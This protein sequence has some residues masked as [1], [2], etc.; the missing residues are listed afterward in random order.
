M[1]ERYISPGDGKRRGGVL[2]PLQALSGPDFTGTMGHPAHE[3]VD[4]LSE[5]G[6]LVWHDLP[7]APT[8]E[9]GCPYNSPSALAGDPRRIDIELVARSGALT[10]AQ[11]ARYFTK[12]ERGITNEEGTLQKLALLSTAFVQ[13][14][15][16]PSSLPKARFDRWK[17]QQGSWL[18]SFAAYTALSAGHGTGIWQQW[19][20][21]ARDHTPEA[22]AHVRAGLE[23]KVAQYVQWLFHEQAG[24][25]KTEANAKDVGIIGDVPFYVSGFSADVWANRSLFSVDDQGYPLRRSGV[26]PDYFSPDGQL[27]GNPIYRWHAPEVRQDLYK[28]Y[29]ERFKR[30]LEYTNT[31][32]ID[33]ARALAN[34]FVIDDPQATTAREAQLEAGPS[35]DF[36]AY[37]KREFGTPMPF[38]AEDLGDI[39]DTVRSLIA[40][41][42]LAGLGIPQ[43]AP[44]GNNAAGNEHH[45]DSASQLRVFY[46]GT[47]DND[48][49]NHFVEGLSADAAA[50]FNYY[51]DV[52]PGSDPA[53]QVI[54]KIWASP[55]GLA[56][57]S[58]ADVLSMGAEGRYNIPGTVQNENWSRRYS[59]DAF[60]QKIDWLKAVTA[61]TGRIS[62]PE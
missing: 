53:T 16:T 23:Y 20:P 46:S 45:P 60:S 44:W 35:D 4:G 52:V 21:S 24:A 6:G 3:F 13:F 50:E 25:L 5:A 59:L 28:W 30:V 43:F 62:Q 47:H 48:T 19:Q 14:D 26:P 2:L 37:L 36:L 33:H 8:D 55:A 51:F 34:Y 61:D 10:S 22:L 29:S 38:I 27:W 1:I 40:R 54:E 49:V 7:F 31:V 56:I 18:D 17:A 57:A 41:H 39:D 9:Y 32:R 12:V 58:V 15:V 42:G 11:E